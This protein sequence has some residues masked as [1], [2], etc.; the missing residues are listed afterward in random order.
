MVQFTKTVSVLLFY[1]LEIC[2]I[3][4]EPKLKFRENNKILHS[5]HYLFC[6]LGLF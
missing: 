2:F 4:N 1:F 3:E 5:C 6:D